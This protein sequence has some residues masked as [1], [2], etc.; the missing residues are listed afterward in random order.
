[1]P[2]MFIGV[3]VALQP[4]TKNILKRLEP[5]T[6]PIAMRLKS[7]FGERILNTVWSSHM[8]ASFEA[9]LEVKG[10]DSIGVLNTITKTISEDYLQP[11][12][13]I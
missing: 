4:N 13:W 12:P 7:S 1:M 10:I 8:N 5:I 9:T 11:Y 6:F 2:C 3:I